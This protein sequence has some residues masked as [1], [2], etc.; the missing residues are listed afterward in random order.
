MA[1]K[2]LVLLLVLALFPVLGD[3]AVFD[4]EGSRLVNI[5]VAGRVERVILTIQGLQSAGSYPTDVTLDIGDDGDLDWQRRGYHSVTPFTLG[6]LHFMSSDNAAA[7][8]ETMQARVN[9]DDNY[10]TPLGYIDRANKYSDLNEAGGVL[11]IGSTSRVASQRISIHADTGLVDAFIPANNNVNGNF[12]VYVAQGGSTYYCQDNPAYP[13]SSCTLTPAQAMTESH[14]ARRAEPIPLE[15]QQAIENP[16]FADEINDYLDGCGGACLVPFRF[17]SDSAGIIDY[18]IQII[19]ESPLPTITIADQGASYLVSV[20]PHNS[21]TSLSYGFG[22]RP[23]VYVMYAF[24]EDDAGTLST[25][26]ARRWAIIKSNLPAKWDL[27]TEN[28]HPM[29]FHFYDEP[30]IA[31]GYIRA[32][33]SSGEFLYAAVD[34]F[35]TEHP[36]IEDNNALYIVIDANNLFPI[37]NIYTV[38]SS[39]GSRYGIGDIFFSGFS[40]ANAKPSGYEEEVM[41]NELLHEIAHAFI[42]LPNSNEFLLGHPRCYTGGYGTTGSPTGN[43]GCYEFNTVLNEFRPLMTA[44]AAGGEMGLDGLSRMSLGILSKYE[45]GHYTF[46]E[47]VV[48]WSGSPVRYTWSQTGSFTTE[49]TYRQFFEEN[50]EPSLEM[51]WN[52]QKTVTESNVGPVA[53]FSIQK[54]GQ[55]NRSILVFAGADAYPEHFKVF[56]NGARSDSQVLGTPMPSQLTAEQSVRK[57]TNSILQLRLAATEPANLTFRFYQ[58]GN[59]INTIRNSTSS[60]VHDVSLQLSPGISYSYD[61]SLCSAGGCASISTQHLTSPT[62]IVDP[63]SIFNQIDQVVANGSSVRISTPVS[64]HGIGGETVSITAPE[65][66]GITNYTVNE[67]GTNKMVTVD[68]TRI[69]WQANLTRQA[70]LLFSVPAPRVLLRNFSQS[71]NHYRKDLLVT[72]DN[73]FR[74][75]HVSINV[76]PSIPH[77]KLY[78]YDGQWVDV[79]TRFDLRISS[80]VATFHNFNTSNQSFI[81]EGSCFENWV[82]TAWTECSNDRQSC[83][84]WVDQNACGTVAEKPVSEQRACDSDDGSSSGR[85]G[86]GGGGGGSGTNVPVTRPNV[87]QQDHYS[88]NYSGPVRALEIDFNINLTAPIVSVVETAMTAPELAQYARYAS[89]DIRSSVDNKF[90]TLIK[91]T[92][93][94]NKSWMEENGIEDVLLFQRKA[95][96]W[97][98]VAMEPIQDTN[99]ETVFEASVLEAGSFMIVGEYDEGRAQAE[100]SRKPVRQGS[101]EENETSAEQIA[102]P[103]PDGDM[104]FYAIAGL[105]IAVLLGVLVIIH[106]RKRPG[107]Q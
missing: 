67:S 52:L 14:L 74:D 60:R 98:K 24:A 95:R 47:G 51:Y 25:D 50:E 33:T 65:W 99:L 21:L 68:G 104:L 97:S 30:L 11:A 91:F 87:T 6:D 69:T 73:P 84:S 85:G 75:V 16:A 17:T 29:I 46:Y 59:L 53:S 79:T 34:A 61:A 56:G 9:I 106:Y 107:N 20:S 35:K 38:I 88:A 12:Y 83:I 4:A 15:S 5:N 23:D 42:L 77:Y 81:L 1:Y 48:S 63:S 7:N 96:S 86:G 18:T 10:G 92:M 43:A 27:L 2:R 90:I 45:P 57:L 82:C 103:E 19:Y 80:G 40:D 26:E 93:P 94:V 76:N 78:W 3:Q 54:S 71:A 66:R 8:D 55:S 49:H 36:G 28:K 105:L 70:S 72:S 102:E 22:K 32:D 13:E 89:F 39:Y 44:A 64:Y 100:P 31:Y 62:T 41:I 37:E 58:N 101:E